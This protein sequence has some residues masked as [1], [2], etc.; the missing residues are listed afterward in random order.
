MIYRIFSIVALLLF[1]QNGFTEDETLPK[2]F[3]SDTISIDS[4]E[5]VIHFTNPKQKLIKIENNLDLYGHKFWIELLYGNGNKET[6]ISGD[7]VAV[8]QPI[9]GLWKIKV[10]SFAKTCGL[11]VSRRINGRTESVADLR[12]NVFHDEFVIHD[13]ID[14]FLKYF[15]FNVGSEYEYIIIRD[16]KMVIKKVYVKEFE[17]MKGERIR[18]FV[19]STETGFDLMGLFYLI[20]DSCIYNLGMFDI[21]SFEVDSILPRG[22]FLKDEMI[23]TEKISVSDEGFYPKQTIQMLR[24]EDISVPAGSFD[25]CIK[26]EIVNHWKEDSISIETLW[27]A[28]N[29]GIVMRRANSVVEVL[30]SY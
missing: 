13:T 23:A 1:S 3:G 25:D 11:W 8:F 6:F 24:I 19:D 29:V 22:L 2:F 14:N 10:M 5:V 9:N 21:A 7:K 27:I 12:F 15:P 17:S 20:E 30:Q 28:K 4:I 18:Y 26:L 16:K